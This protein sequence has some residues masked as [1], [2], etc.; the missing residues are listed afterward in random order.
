[1]QSTGPQMEER[2]VSKRDKNGRFVAEPKPEP[3]CENCRFFGDD[4]CYR[5][6]PVREYGESIFPVTRSWWWCGEHQSGMMRGGSDE[7]L[8]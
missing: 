2:A 5:Y 4:E 1:M 8:G 3:I 7:N 6:P